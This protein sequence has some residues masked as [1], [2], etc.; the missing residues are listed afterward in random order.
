MDPKQHLLAIIVVESQ[1]LPSMK[2]QTKCAKAILGGRFLS[3]TGGSR[4]P[5]VP[6][7]GVQAI[8]AKYS[9][10]DTPCRSGTWR[11]AILT[12]RL[13]AT[14]LRHL[15]LGT[16]RPAILTSRLWAAGLRHL[17]MLRHLA[18]RNPNLQVNYYK[19]EV[20]TPQLCKHCLGNKKPFLRSNIG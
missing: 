3:G 17:C 4:E 10:L 11:P 18:T 1:G 6:V 12:S 9:C 8:L 5:P 2:C 14:G 13:W 20:R 15:G 19:A 7:M 16:W